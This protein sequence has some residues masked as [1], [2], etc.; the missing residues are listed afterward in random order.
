MIKM[1]IN[2]IKDGTFFKK[3]FNKI[4]REIII[5]FQ[6]KLYSNMALENRIVFLTFQGDYSCNLKYI[7]EELIKQGVDCELVWAVRDDKHGEFPKEIKTVNRNT[8]EFYRLA[9]SS[10]III[11]NANNF[12]FLKLKKRKDQILIQTWHGSMGFKKIETNKNKNWMKKS[13]YLDEITDYCIVNSDFEIDVFKNTFWKT[14]EK[15]KYGHPRNDI[16]FNGNK[17]LS[18]KIK[19]KYNLDN[20]TKIVLYAP[21]F[22]DN[23]DLKSDRKS[24]V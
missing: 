8:L 23:I 22:R 7:A 5:I 21:T 11:D 10:K 17:E 19:K 20:D 2:S 1:I 12:E 3:S 16:L 24:V 6:K 18:L 14:T 4:K 9:S 13:M 15:L